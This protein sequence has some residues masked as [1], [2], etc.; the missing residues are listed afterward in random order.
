LK[1]ASSPSLLLSR[2]LPWLSWWQELILNWVASWDAVGSLTA[3]SADK[4]SHCSWD[5]PTDLDLK[6]ME[7]EELLQ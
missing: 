6:R 5:I 2:E 3:V 4:E 1:R 7:L